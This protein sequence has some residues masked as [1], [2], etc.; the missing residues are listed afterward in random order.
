MNAQELRAEVAKANVKKK[1]IAK[2][3]GISKQ[4]ITN[5]MNGKNEFKASEIRALAK[6]LNLSIEKVNCIF[7]ELDVN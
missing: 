6:C 1:D 7:F 5:K 3:L 4:A 2:M